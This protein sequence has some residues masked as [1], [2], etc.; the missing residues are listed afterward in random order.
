MTSRPPSA[1]WRFSDSG[2]DGAPAATRMASKGACSGTPARA[3]TLDHHHVGI[4]ETLQRGAR[5]GGEL[6]MPLDRD[7]RA[8]RARP[9]PPPRS[10]S[11]SPTSSTRDDGR[12]ARRFRHQR[13]DIGLRD[14]LALGDRQRIVLVG[15]LRE[16]R[17]ER[18]PRAAPSPWQQGP[19]DRRCRAPTSWR[20]IMFRRASA[21][22]SVIRTACA[23]DGK[24]PLLCPVP[25]NSSGKERNGF[26]QPP[27]R[28][29]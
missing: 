3:V 29:G 27:H 26:S 4:A 6:R 16:F 22:R 18:R 7:D 1:S 19:S 20:S 14:G 10:R 12:D 2:G 23:M 21:N 17:R 24:R 11:R 13:N 8:R 15:R 9:A 25:V 28:C 5:A